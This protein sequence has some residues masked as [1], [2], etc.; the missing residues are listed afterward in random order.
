MEARANHAR[1][2]E[3]DTVAMGLS[4]AITKV[5]IT[6]STRRRGDL[7]RFGKRSRHPPEPAIDNARP[8]LL[9]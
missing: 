7:H 2:P 1:G 6:P 5:K 8:A 4:G 3:E 9:L